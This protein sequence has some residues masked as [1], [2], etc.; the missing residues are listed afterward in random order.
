MSGS[1]EDGAASR[2]ALR[3]A[4][5]LGL[6]CRRGLRWGVGSR[7]RAAPLAALLTVCAPARAGAEDA[8]SSADPNLE[9]STTSASSTGWIGA[10]T[11]VQWQPEWRRFGWVNGV[12]IG[13]GLGAAGVALAV[14]PDE[15]SP[16]RWRGAFDEG[17]RSWARADSAA[18]RRTVRRLSDVAVA[19]EI[20]YAL[21][22]DAVLNAGVYRSSP[23]VAWQLALIDS[24][25]LALA[26]GAQLVTATWVSR[27]RPYVRDCGE[28]DVTEDGSSCTGGYPYRSFYSG[29]TSTAF[30]MAAATC[31]HHA[32][33]PLYGGRARWAPCVGSL[34]VGMVAGGARIVSDQ[35]FSTDVLVGAVAGSTIGWLVP[36]LHYETGSVST[37]TNSVSSRRGVPDLRVTVVP[38]P[39]GIGVI[40]TF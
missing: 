1:A 29:H 3:A 6:T 13:A 25:V 2:L 23:D 20:S 14:G 28:R 39:R 5:R 34:A 35:H 31:T 21:V 27:E 4:G 10:G 9:P 15:D 7:R 38:N 22:G 26:L 17:V 33:V 32:Y 8:R 30:A 11:P 37:S 40:G 19:L 24:Q 16:R 18:T 36:W 12:L